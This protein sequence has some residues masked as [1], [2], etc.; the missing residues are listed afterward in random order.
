MFARLTCM[1]VCVCMCASANMLQVHVA[2]CTRRR[3]RRE[4]SPYS[5]G[6]VRGH[7]RRRALFL[8]EV[9]PVEVAWSL[10]SAPSCFHKCDRTGLTLRLASWSFLHPARKFRLSIVATIFMPI[11]R[12]FSF[13]NYQ[14][15]LPFFNCSIEIQSRHVSLLEN[16]IIPMERYRLTIRWSDGRWTL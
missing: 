8:R 5:R 12:L 7:E 10:T 9:I 4:S 15:S 2:V 6:D 1:Y 14:Y 3:R 16:G 13:I 11:F